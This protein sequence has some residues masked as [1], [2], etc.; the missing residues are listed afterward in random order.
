MDAALAILEFNLLFILLLPR[1][2]FR[3][4]D[5]RHSLMWF[6]TAAP[7]LPCAGAL[8]LA[9]GGAL[10]PAWAGGRPREALLA[11]GGFCGAGSCALI[12]LTPG[13]RRTPLA[14]WHQ[15]NDAPRRIVT[16]GAY[17]HIRHP[18]YT[19]FS[20]CLAGAALALPHPATIACLVYGAL[21]LNHTA[22]RE[23]PR[24]SA[25]EFGAAYRAYK[26]RTGR[27][28][29]RL[30]AAAGAGAEVGA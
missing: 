10:E 2:F 26:A 1:L 21:A 14:R 7:S 6:V 28:L 25:S 15:D 4:P 29:P 9:A 8:A 24:L 16:Y 3:N 30:G 19:S 27:F 18:F 11:L 17:K 12:G 5:G 20:I 23:E 22:S 13:T